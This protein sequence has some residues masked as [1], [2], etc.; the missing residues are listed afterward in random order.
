L[1]NAAPTVLL[2]RPQAQ[3]QRFAEGLG[4]AKVVISPVLEVQDKGLQVDPRSYD[5][6]IFTSEN[7]VRAAAAAAD[8]RGLRGFAV[9]QR[10]A[11]VGEASGLKLRP[12]NGSADDLVALISR[13]RPAGRLLHLHGTHSR[14]DVAQRLKNAGIETDSAVIYDQI[15]RPLTTE[16]RLLLG[17]DG[18]V[19]LPLFSP[20]T[21]S[22]L[23]PMCQ[24]ARADL[25]LIA[26]SQAVLDAWAGPKPLQARALAKPTADAMREEVLRQTG[27]VA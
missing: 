19:L 3:S 13:D 26:M 6:L 25:I 4:E 20:R 11:M 1:S 2:T 15:A 22:L 18:V 5:G 23:G 17:Q 21:A 7:G 10:T 8:L 27:Q 12:A 24:N 9:G 14:G 16:A